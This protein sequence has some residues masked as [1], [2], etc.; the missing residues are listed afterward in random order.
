MKTMTCKSLGGPCE[1]KLCAGTWD[2]MVRAMT[3]H[4]ME[5]HPDTA[6]AMEKNAQ[7]RPEEM[8]QGNK[9]EVGSDRGNP[10]LIELVIGA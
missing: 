2:D 9:A 7:R 4:V 10:V 6:K 8:G 1:A 3:K 5:N